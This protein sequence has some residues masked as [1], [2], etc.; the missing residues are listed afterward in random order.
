MKTFFGKIIGRTGVLAGLGL[1]LLGCYS[2]DTDS[3]DTPVF[4]TDPVESDY[5]QVC[6]TVKASANSGA[7]VDITISAL[8]ADD[9]KTVVA[10]TK[11]V[12]GGN[13][14]LA[15]SRAV[16]P[17]GY[18]YI[19]QSFRN[20]VDIS[21]PKKGL[22]EDCVR[23]VLEDPSG[24]YAPDTVLVPVYFT[25]NPHEQYQD[26]IDPS[27]SYAHIIKDT[28]SYCNYA[29]LFM[30]SSAELVSS[31]QDYRLSGIISNTDNEPL[32]DIE[33]IIYKYDEN[34]QIVASDTTR[35]HFYGRYVVEGNSYSSRF[36]IVASDP[37][38]IYESAAL[39]I[40][41]VVIKNEPTMVGE[42]F[43]TLQKK[44]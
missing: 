42:A 14:T 27:D 24:A 7:L 30:Q 15:G 26:L 1:T 2:C 38:G 18:A 22:W 39:D 17:Q 44:E 36:R 37:K 20:S 29:E 10:T 34:E 8:A 33:L 16:I 23:L 9:A 31:Y 12:I 4:T 5:F 21:S 35:S 28:A 41:Y 25:K 11:T 32:P 13:F 40:D 19:I 3:D 43:L 6:G